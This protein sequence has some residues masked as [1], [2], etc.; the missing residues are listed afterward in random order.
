MLQSKVLVDFVRTELARAADPSRAPAMAAYMKTSQPFYG[1][2]APQVHAIAKAAR[3]H[4]VPA[5]PTQYR[6]N[7]LALWKLPHRE[8]RYAAIDYAQQRDFQTPGSIPLYERMIREGAW[9]DLVDGIAS[10][11]LGIAYLD[12][13]NAIRPVLD[14]WIEDPDLWIRRS[15]ILAQLRHKRETD[16]A[17]LFR[18]CLRSA[19]EREFFI[20]KAIG[21]ALRAYS[22]SEPAKVKAFLLKHRRTL[23]PL[24]FREGARQLIRAGNF[25]GSS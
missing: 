20:R 19:A 5:N 24:S 7:V 15:A 2:A 17:Q 8:A 16:S 12:H 23:S 3:R 1:V 25:Q 10:N 21:W 4:F 9:W 6:G 11:L 18:Y 13:R 22:Y 14:R